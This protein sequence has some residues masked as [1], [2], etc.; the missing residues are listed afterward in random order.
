MLKLK[1]E[2]GVYRIS[3]H[4]IDRLNSLLADPIR[5][6]LLKMVSKPGREVVLSLKGISFIDGSG[7]EAIM[8]VVNQASEMGSRFRICDVSGDVYELLK[9]MKVKVMFEINPVR[10]KV[11]IPAS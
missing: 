5:E 10:S 11:Q 9:L 4:R 3:F 7:F 2:E 6:E 8:A 1:I